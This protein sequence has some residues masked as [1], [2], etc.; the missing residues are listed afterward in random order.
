MDY[1]LHA[2]DC[3]DVLRTL[4]AHTVDAIVTDPPYGLAFMGHKWDHAVP[5]PEYFRELLRVAK[6]GAHLVAFGGTRLF[7]RLAVS[8]EDAGWELRDTLSWLYGSGFPKSLAID[9]AI[10]REAG[11]VREVVGSMRLTGTARIVGGQGGN[12]AGRADELYGSRELR[13]ELPITAPATELAKRFDGYGTALKPAWEPIVLAMAPLVGTYAANARA[14]DVAGLNID[15]ARVGDDGGT[16]SVGGPNFLNKVYGRGMGGLGVAQLPGKGRWPA[17]LV[18]DEVAAE[19]LDLEAGER[20]SGSRAAGVRT[21]LGYNGAN[22]DG[23]PAIAGSSGGASRFFYTAKAGREDRT[24]DNAHP[25]VKPTDLMRWLVRLVAPPRPA[26]VL[27][28]FMGSGSTG[29][30]CVVEGVDFVGID[31]EQRWVDVARARIRRAHRIGP[32][33]LT[34]A[35]GTKAIQHG[36]FA[37][38]LDR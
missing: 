24:D 10:D 29:V 5:G 36:L 22:G 20:V 34:A 32:E 27:D 6:P 14:H 1:T 7:H 37:D 35:D 30:A 3:L 2:G 4:G 19:A 38:E 18:L 9:K 28:P 23:G 13:D 16:M 25:T 11:A 31:R 21:G 12:S 26:L 8:I 17:N 33:V 15:A